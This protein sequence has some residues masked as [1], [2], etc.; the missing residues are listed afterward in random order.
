MAIIADGKLG[1]E[2]G[3]RKTQDEEFV[4]YDIRFLW[5]GEPMMRREIL[6][7]GNDYWSGRLD[8][9]FRADDHGSDTLIPALRSALEHST[10]GYWEPIEP[11]VT[12]YFFPGITL[13]DLPLLWACAVGEPQTQAQQGYLHRLRAERRSTKAEDLWLLVARVDAMNFKDEDMF[14]GAGPALSVQ[15]ER[16]QLERFVDDLE[17]EC[18]A[19]Q[20]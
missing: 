11:W 20:R 13:D 10:A 18:A 2:I 14:S 6:K 12:L 16:Q 8:G 15:V 4:E 17:Q 1:M 9:G 7:V 19:A 5:Q 3:F